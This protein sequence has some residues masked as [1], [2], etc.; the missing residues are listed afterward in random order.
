MELVKERGKERHHA[1]AERQ[2]VGNHGDGASPSA[3]LRPPCRMMVVADGDPGVFM[4][5]TAMLDVLASELEERLR[6]LHE[7]WGPRAP[8]KAGSL[9]WHRSCAQFKPQSTRTR[10]PASSSCHGL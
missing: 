1:A 2:D 8:R 6:T 7:W 5:L 10:G 4:A 9:P 3:H